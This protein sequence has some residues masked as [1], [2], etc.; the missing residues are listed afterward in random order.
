MKL[1]VIGATGS[2]GSAACLAAIGRGHG[3]TAFVRS[4]EKLGAMRDQMT[5]VVGDLTDADAVRAAVAGHDAVISALGSSPDAAQLDVPATAMRNV[6]AAME[7]TGVRRL[8]G[9]AGAAVSVPGEQKPLRGR[10]ASFLVRLMARNVVEAKQREFEVVR[11][12]DL[13]WTMIRPPNVVDGE[14]TGRVVIGET[15]RG[16][17]ISSGDVGVALV[18][19][20]EGNAHVRGAPYLSAGPR[21]ESAGP[22]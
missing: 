13:D 18:Q 15:L 4:P 17:R 8:V 2:I 6:L 14:A 10:I 11:A 20:A 12:S 9:I 16:F 3:V 5:I 21:G 22:R 7:A 19:L 1:L